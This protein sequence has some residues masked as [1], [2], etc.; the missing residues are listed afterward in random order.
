M[1]LAALRK[2]RA[3]RLKIPTKMETAYTGR[4]QIFFILDRGVKRFPGDLKLWMQYFEYSR[5]QQSHIKLKELFA[6]CLR[7]HTTKPEMWIYAASVMFEDVADMMG[8]RSYMQRGLRFC[9]DNR[10]IWLQFAKLEMIYIEKIAARRRILGLDGQGKRKRET[11]AEV[12]DNDDFIGLHA[13]TAEDINPSL[14]KADGMDEIALRNLENTPAVGGAIPIAIFDEAMKHFKNDERLAQDFFETVLGFSLAP[15]RRKVLQHISDH[16]KRTNRR[17]LTNWSCQIRLA[18]FEIDPKSPKFP[19]A[20]RQVLEMVKTAQ[21]D[22]QDRKPQ[23][24]EMAVRHLSPFAA[25]EGLDPDLQKVLDATIR[26]HLKFMGAANAAKV[27]EDLV[28]RKSLQEA[29]YILTFARKLWPD[30]ERLRVAWVAKEAQIEA[31][32]NPDVGP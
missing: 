8:A 19:A 29:G 28:E 4:R 2:K 20:L 32:K 3:K 31:R 17:T 26:E 5:K 23:V 1:Q 13:V 18:T 9:K 16:V 15:C 6:R 14:S 21:S 30:H 22:L 27:A 24:A 12:Q 11:P 7:L 10:E 25:Q